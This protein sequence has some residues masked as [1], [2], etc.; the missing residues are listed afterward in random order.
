MYPG[1]KACPP[2]TSRLFPVPHGSEVGYGC[3]NHA[4]YLKNGWR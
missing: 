3:A 1:T 4:W 2:I